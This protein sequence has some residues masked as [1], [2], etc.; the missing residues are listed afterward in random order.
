MSKIKKLFLGFFS[1]I[2]QIFLAIETIFG[3]QRT[4]KKLELV[5]FVKAL[6][7]IYQHI[8]RFI[9]YILPLLHYFANCQSISAIKL[10]KNQVF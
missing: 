8:L 9:L 6:S 5:K 10:P 2:I 1:V 3:L 7:Y 4:F